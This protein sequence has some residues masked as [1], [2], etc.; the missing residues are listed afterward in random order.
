MVAVSGAA[1]TTFGRRKDGSSFRD[2]AV[3][4]CDAAIAMSDVDAAA[5]DALLVASESDFFTLQ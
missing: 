5:I 2:R 3:P 1:L 4:A